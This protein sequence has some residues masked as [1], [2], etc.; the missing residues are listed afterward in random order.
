MTVEELNNHQLTPTADQLSNL[1]ALSDVLTRLEG[2]IGVYFKVNSGLRSPELQATINPKAPH[3]AH[4]TGEAADISDIDGDLY[5]WL[6]END[7]YLVELGLYVEQR[8][9]TPTW[10]HLQT[11][12]TINRFFIP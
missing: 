2:I 11:R 12:P 8:A 3:S 10:V 4:L 1:Q 6:L 5:H 9:Y 7:H